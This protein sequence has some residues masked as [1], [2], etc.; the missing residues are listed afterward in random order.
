MDLQ[1]KLIE[2]SE[3]NVNFNVANGNFVIKVKYNDEWSIIKP[4]NNDIAFYRDENDDSIYY[5]IAPI[6]ISLDKLFLAID[7]TIEYNR[8]LE[9]KVELFRNKMAELQ[10]IF[11]QESLDVLNTLEFKVK[12]KKK[13]KKKEK[14]IKEN[15]DIIN[16]NVL[17]NKDESN[18]NVE[19]TEVKEENV[20]EIDK[21][22]SELIK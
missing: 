3:Y 22:I 19:N 13:K 5:Y 8:E 21:K 7:E 17:E 9:L 2:L 18:D 11:A 14:N 6:T 12:K 15:D 4:D 10:E 1:E 20:S 16:N